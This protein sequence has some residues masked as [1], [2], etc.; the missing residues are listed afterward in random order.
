MPTVFAPRDWKQMLASP[1]PSSDN[2]T[3]V[4]GYQPNW[5]DNNA[6]TDYQSGW[7]E[8]E[9][10]NLPKEQFYSLTGLNKINPEWIQQ[11]ETGAKPTEASSSE[12][13]GA[14]ETWTMAYPYKVETFEPKPVS[15]PWYETMGEILTP[16]PGGMPGAGWTPQQT[17]SWL[18][19]T[20]GEAALMSLPGAVPTV[21]SLGIG[22]KV[23]KGAEIVD[24][25]AEQLTKATLS[26][27][28]KPIGWAGKQVLGKIASYEQKLE[29]HRIARTLGLTA[30]AYKKQ[31]K[32]ITGKISMRDMTSD[33]AGKFINSL[34]NREIKLPFENMSTTTASKA[35][36][37]LSLELSEYL[38]GIKPKQIVT[39]ATEKVSL[40]QRVSDKV[41]GY[42]NRAD[43]VERLMDKADGYIAQKTIVGG[44][45][46]QTFINPVE[47]AADKEILGMMSAREGLDNFIKQNGMNWKQL[48][49]NQ[50]E[51]APG[52][53]LTLGE[54]LGIYR[55]SLNPDNL[56][57]IVKG[58]GI[59]QDVVKQ[60]VDGL[61]PQEKALAD[62]FGQ[63]YKVNETPLAEAYKMATGRTMKLVQDYFPIIV[64]G[65]ERPLGDILAQEVTARYTRKY[66][67]S[68]ISKGFTMARTG[69]ATQGIQLDVFDIFFRRL[70]E[71]EHYKAFS[72]V[73]RDL[74]RIAGNPSFKN[75]YIGKEGRPAYE[76]LTQWLKNIA[77]TD[78][79]R[80]RDWGERVMQQLRVNASAAVLGFKITTMMNQ[81]PA[82][83]VGASEIGNIPALKGT[84]A[85]LSDMKGWTT[86]TKRLMPQIYKRSMEREITEMKLL[87]AMA[88]RPWEKLIANTRET[89]AWLSVTADRLVANSIARGAFD[90]ALKKGFSEEMAAKYATKM[91]QRTQAMWSPKDVPEIYRTGGEAM[92]M[93]TAFTNQLNNQW[94]IMRHDIYGMAKAGQLSKG[95]LTKRVM[96]GIVLQA[97]LIGWISRSRPEQDA[98]EV[99]QDIVGNN[100]ASVPIF[101]SMLSAGLS[102]FRDTGAITFEA[103]QKGVDEMYY[104]S[105]G[106]WG[107]ALATLPELAGYATGL[108]ASQGRRI[109]DALLDI[110]QG[111]SNDWLRLIWSE[112]TRKQGGSE[113]GTI[114]SMEGGG[115]YSP[116]W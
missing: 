72:P 44:K 35:S 58:N 42:I 18:G 24:I 52:I 83:F 103:I 78:P 95:D 4:E 36:R 82:W 91:I 41:M 17:F 34:G 97:V 37:E 25:A 110:A 3:D 107:K 85:Y 62:W 115:D 98:K 61:S 77:E 73:I 38:G 64:K 108:P 14:Y 30:D 74:Q 12:F 68:K 59:S 47:K 102:G 23:L 8:R 66:P 55:H 96:E 63:F 29:V 48:L 112:Y 26:P 15:K 109:T 28:T 1:P 104:M 90:D 88:S 46:M 32:N 16:G 93:L 21:K 27:I 20:V 79:L 33:E 69:R 67:S 5:D 80:A 57:H 45:M 51:V 111:K 106:N 94:N 19:Q 11:F 84:L 43:R 87:T 75:A 89:A 2:T 53:Q 56:R 86:L 116:Q 49:S 22:G 54:R 71:M 13:K 50:T 99:A 39:K 81:I 31:A 9:P 7:D 100:M 60:I 10:F 6:T 76:V 70:N 113:Q 114:P 101:G 105:K 65:D 40:W 92:R